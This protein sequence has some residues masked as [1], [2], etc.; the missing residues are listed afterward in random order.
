MMTAETIRLPK[1]EPPILWADG[2]HDDSIVLRHLLR[3]GA[4]YAMKQRAVIVA[5]TLKDLPPGVYRLA[6]AN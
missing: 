2:A 1:A 4:A 3:G 5:P 6:P